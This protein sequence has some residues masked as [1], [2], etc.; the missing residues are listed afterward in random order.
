LLALR[1]THFYRGGSIIDGLLRGRTG[2]GTN[3]REPAGAE[4]RLARR[5]T[6]MQAIGQEEAKDRRF[7]EEATARPGG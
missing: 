2:Q 1:W 3:L 6:M 7:L 4:V 5:G